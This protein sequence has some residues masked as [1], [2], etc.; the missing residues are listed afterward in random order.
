MLGLGLWIR[1]YLN[2]FLLS[3]KF[4]SLDPAIWAFAVN[5]SA[6]RSRSARLMLLSA[7]FPGPASGVRA[8][9]HT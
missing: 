8:V 2:L 7:A 1:V 9:V 5:T 3:S 6:L 4:L